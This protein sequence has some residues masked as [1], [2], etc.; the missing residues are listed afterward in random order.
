MTRLIVLL[1]I[2]AVLCLAAGCAEKG[3]LVLPNL[4]PETYVSIADSVRHPTVYI[5]TLHWWGEDPDGEIAGFEYRWVIDEGEPGSPEDAQ[6]VFTEEYTKEFHLP[7]SKG[8]STH[9]IYVRAID[10]DGAI[11][12]SPSSMTLPL[13]NSPPEVWIWDKGALPDTSY[14]ALTIKWHG[15]DPEGTET[16]DHFVVWLDGEI[17]NARILSAQDTIVGLGH[18]D[19]GGR[20]G[21]R[22]L[23]VMAV[24]TGMDSSSIDTYSWY[25]VEPVGDV[26]LIDDLSHSYA[27]YKTTAAY[28]RSALDSCVGTYSVLDFSSFGG[29]VYTYNFEGLF[30]FFDVVIWA[31]DPVRFDTLYLE[32]AG[33]AVP[34]YVESG[35]RF[36]LTSLQAV[37]T[38]GAFSDS[39]AF[40]VFGIDSL[41]LY[42]NKTDFELKNTWEIQGNTDV[43]LD[44]VRAKS[45]WSGVECMALSAGVTPLFYVPPGTVTGQAEDYYLG[46]LN[47]YGSGKA[48]LLTL[49]ISRCDKYGNNRHQLCRIIDLLRS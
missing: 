23:N 25:T 19:F 43:G 35:G 7:V 28:Y 26:L 14:P 18:E 44:T 38:R 17:E 33:L 11:D 41:Y 27:G 8:I 49:P 24:D 40:E 36:L 12:P 3:D 15:E 20:Y 46:V 22:T 2:G 30:D 29:P 37:G 9:T 21:E 45:T 1:I 47:S 42:N 39:I 5:Q 4:P 10:D 34:G 6:W 16:I 48:A 13:T 32:P 31:N